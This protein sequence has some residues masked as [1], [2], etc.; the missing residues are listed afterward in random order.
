MV[1][2]SVDHLVAVLNENVWS[3]LL[4]WLISHWN[5]GEET[6]CYSEDYYQLWSPVQ[7]DE[8]PY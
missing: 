5:A 3:L 6:I 4:S 7:R 8:F 2:Y 1:Q